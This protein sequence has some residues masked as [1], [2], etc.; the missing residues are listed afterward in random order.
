M[1]ESPVVN[2]EGGMAHLLLELQKAT[3]KKNDI[4]SNP[5]MDHAYKKA[6]QWINTL[7][8]V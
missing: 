8:N 4:N 3:L 6:N 7:L 5:T 1:M 2:I